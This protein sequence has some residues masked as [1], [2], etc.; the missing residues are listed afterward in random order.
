MNIITPLE[1]KNADNFL[2]KE[3]NP[4]ALQFYSVG[5][6]IQKH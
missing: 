2:S 1:K 3:N 5:Y 4:E 6:N